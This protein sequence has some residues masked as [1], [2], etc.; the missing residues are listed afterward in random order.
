MS[1]NNNELQGELSKVIESL[2]K[3]AEGK[4]Q[5]HNAA[6]LTLFEAQM[7]LLRN[8][9]I[10]IPAQLDGLVNRLIA[11]SVHETSKYKTVWINALEQIS[12]INQQTVI[13][14]KKGVSTRFVKLK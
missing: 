4:G 5:I 1:R 8:L 3:Y 7:K 10:P 9:G 12:K 11:L 2:L 6:K 14:E 13:E